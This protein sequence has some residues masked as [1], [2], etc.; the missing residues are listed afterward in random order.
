LGWEDQGVRGWFLQQFGRPPKPRPDLRVVVYHR[1]GCH[2]CDVAWE[3]LAEARRAYGF[4][5]ERKDVDEDPRL[6]AEYGE[7]VP[8]VTVNGKVRFRGRVNAV[9]LQRLLDGAAG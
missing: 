4:A 7:C 6:V 9:L 3:Q 5:L 2:L 8:V 1:Q